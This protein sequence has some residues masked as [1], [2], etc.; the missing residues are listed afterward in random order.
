M[1]LL[2]G[3]FASSR[4]LISFPSKSDS[5]SASN[6]STH[7]PLCQDLVRLGAQ[8]SGRV[9][10]AGHAQ[11]HCSGAWLRG[12]SLIVNLV[13]T[14]LLLSINIMATS[15]LLKVRGFLITRQWEVHGDNTGWP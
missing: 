8:L 12:K 6:F 14:L 7:S 10:L 13:A 11:R 2:F 5:V 9:V 15:S 3:S 1:I 4:I